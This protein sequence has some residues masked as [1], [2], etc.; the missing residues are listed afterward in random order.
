MPISL[1]RYAWNAV[2]I[3]KKFALGSMEE[4]VSIFVTEYDS[5]LLKSK[6]IDPEIHRGSEDLSVL[7][8]P[9]KDAGVDVEILT[10]RIAYI[11][12]MY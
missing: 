10:R 6:K 3:R 12:F 4:I 7:G 11:P 2:G 5:S 1:L 8:M 9:Q